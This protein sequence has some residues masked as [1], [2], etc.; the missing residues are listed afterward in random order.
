MSDY[1]LHT[2]TPGALAKMRTH[3]QRYET[4]VLGVPIVILPG[5]W[6]PAHDWSGLFYAENLPDVAGR[7]VL[8]I[9]CGT[10]L[11]SVFAARA[12]AP[13]VVAVDVNP[14]AVENATLNF[15]LLGLQAAEAFVS[16]CFCAVAGKFDVVIF[17]APYHGCKPADMLE[18]A[19]ADEDYQTLRTFFRDVQEHLKPGG[20]VTVGFS[21]S[22]DLPFFRRLV[23]QHGYQVTRTLSDWREGYNCMIF[24]LVRQQPLKGSRRGP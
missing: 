16:D 17:N 23:A 21:E 12:G 3:H 1:H 15:K 9:G 24:D 18:R 6:S 7:D 19:C 10:G 20:L 8:E 2:T 11:I 13:R 22:G 5:V 14:R 4:T